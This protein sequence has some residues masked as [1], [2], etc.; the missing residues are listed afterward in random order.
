MTV[1]DHHPNILRSPVVE[2]RTGLSKTRIDELEKRG[3]FPRRVK[4]SERA[5]GWV[6]SEI[7]QFIRA[8]IEARDTQRNQSTAESLR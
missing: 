8:K 7:D 2:V 4:I 3:L 5:V 1:T 6:E